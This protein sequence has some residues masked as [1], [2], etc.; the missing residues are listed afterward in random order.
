MLD[1][2]ESRM[3]C[4]TGP[5]TRHGCSLH[6]LRCVSCGHD[7]RRGEERRGTAWRGIGK[8]R[9]R[10]AATSAW[11]WVMTVYLAT[12]YN[13]VPCLLAGCLRGGAF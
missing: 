12:S 11:I 6:A 7:A 4:L 8:A 13:R 2:F 5:Q 1:L 10:A 3:N 9:E